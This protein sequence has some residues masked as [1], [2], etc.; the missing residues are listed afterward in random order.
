M[1]C[2]TVLSFFFILPVSGQTDVQMDQGSQVFN[3]WCRICHGEPVSSIDMVGTAK[4]QERY[5]GVVPALLEERTNMTQEFIETIVRNGISIM[6]FYR[7]TEVS[8]EDLDALV[9][10]LTRNNPD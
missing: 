10:Y 2:V 4:L 7:K 9:A 5:Q 3:K 8:D 6:P 1:T